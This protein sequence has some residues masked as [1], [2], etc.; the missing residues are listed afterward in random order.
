MLK[1][2]LAF[3]VP[4]LFAGLVRGKDNDVASVIIRMERAALDGSDKGDPSRFLEIS[5]PDVS[6]VDPFLEQPI[7]G[8]DALREYCKGFPSD[9][10][11]SGEMENAKVQVAGDVAVLTFNYTTKLEKSGRVTRWNCTEVYRQTKDGWRIISTH[12]SFLKPALAK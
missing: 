12:W 2:I 4:V 1:M 6:Y 8:L 11:G 10:P 5:A 9:E 3:M 7:R